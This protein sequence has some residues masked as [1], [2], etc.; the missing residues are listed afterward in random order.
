MSSNLICAI[1]DAFNFLMVK[2]YSQASCKQKM[3]RLFMPVFAFWWKK[4]RYLYFVN[5]SIFIFRMMYTIFLFKKDEKPQV[6]P[7]KYANESDYGLFFIFSIC[8]IDFMTL[9]LLCFSFLSI[10]LWFCLVQNFKSISK[11]LLKILFF[12]LW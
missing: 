1:H 7:K 9:K 8:F 3:L 11:C 6:F 2:T 12:F 5:I 4:K 10:L